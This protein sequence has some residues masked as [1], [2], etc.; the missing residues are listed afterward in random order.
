V[1]D[2]TPLR[3]RIL[4]IDDEESMIELIGMGLQYEGFEVLSANTAKSGLQALQAHAPHLLILDCML[5][6]VDGIAVCQTI[7]LTS[8][9]P[10]LMLTAKGELDDKVTGLEAGAD[11]YLAK[12]FKFRE[13]L[14]RVRALL[15]RAGS[16]YGNQLTF[17]DLRLD[18][19]TRAVTRDSEPV[20]LT[21]REFELLEQ[22]MRRPRHV[23]SRE[24]ILDRVWGW[25]F[26]GDTNVVDVHIAALRAKLRDNERRLI[27]T[28]R[29]VGYSLGA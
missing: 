16:D 25:E 29:G 12:P 28:V 10:I 21:R 20:E 15:R 17:A 27:R 7:R 14:A 26:A 4:V 11:D 5:P 6:D 23:F 24:Q 9:V 19:S 13:L 18:L 8:S 22:L 3:S 2:A 1:D